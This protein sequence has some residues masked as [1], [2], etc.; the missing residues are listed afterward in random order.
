MFRA[1]VS[2]YFT[3]RNTSQALTIERYAITEREGRVTPIVLENIQNFV[4]PRPLK[5]GQARF[6]PTP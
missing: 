2:V 5:V 4:V 6:P 3:S 1:V